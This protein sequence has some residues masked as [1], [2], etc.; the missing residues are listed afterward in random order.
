M[1]SICHKLFSTSL[2]LDARLESMSQGVGNDVY[3]IAAGGS[4]SAMPNDSRAMS[5]P[6]ADL[7]DILTA[8]NDWRAP[9]QKNQRERN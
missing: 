9:H 3:T 2:S 6:Q 7:V 1:G 5:R 4:L 8:R